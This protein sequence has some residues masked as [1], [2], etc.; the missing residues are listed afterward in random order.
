MTP[1]DLP[2]TVRL[3]QLAEECAECT[4]AALKMIR[5]I[6][7]DTPVSKIE[8]REHLIEEIA[9]VSNCMAVL[10]D[11][12]PLSEIIKIMVEKMQ[13]WDHRANQQDPDARRRMMEEVYHGEG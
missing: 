5:A 11:I 13:R 8:A 6:N 3:A 1:R 7:G 12:A 2:L 9:D 10:N 4:Q